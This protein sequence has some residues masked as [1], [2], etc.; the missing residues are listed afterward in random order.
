MTDKIE[1]F[2]FKL[3]AKELEFVE[4]VLLKISSGNHIGLNVKKLEGQSDIFRVKKGRFRIIFEMDKSH[5]EII[6]VGRRNE[7][8]Y[9]DF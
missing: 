8:T 7:K 3:S 1:K 5:I 2:L 6:D 4:N 9:R